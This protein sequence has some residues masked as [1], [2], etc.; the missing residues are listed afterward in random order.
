MV[1]IKAGEGRRDAG[2][3]RGAAEARAGWSLEKIFYLAPKKRA[4][5]VVD[6]LKKTVREYEGNPKTSKMPYSEWKE[7]AI[8][9]IAEAIDEHEQSIH[10]QYRIR[11][12]KDQ[13]FKLVLMMIAVG[14]ATIAF[15]SG[16]LVLGRI[17]NAG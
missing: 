9:V 2:Q 10:Q 4:R 11:E 16:F 17:F 5:T 12:I 1:H 13:V 15:W 6:T 8:D 3:S 14:A 7:I